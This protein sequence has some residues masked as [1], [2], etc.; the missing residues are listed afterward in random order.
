[1]PGVYQ[2]NHAAG[3]GNNCLTSKAP[4]KNRQKTIQGQTLTKPIPNWTAPQA[5]VINA[6]QLRTPALRR[7]RLP[8]SCLVAGVNDEQVKEEIG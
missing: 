5:T 7:M 4:S 1:M 2:V 8:G 6:N 3:T